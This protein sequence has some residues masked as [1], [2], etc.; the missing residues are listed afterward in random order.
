MENMKDTQGDFCTGF[1]AEVPG[2][3]W[4]SWKI[5]GAC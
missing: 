3:S 1:E 2:G 5:E 4:Q